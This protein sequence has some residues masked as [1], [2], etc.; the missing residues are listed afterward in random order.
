MTAAK[1]FGVARR[2]VIQA[3]LAEEV[4]QEAYV[5]IWTHA[6]SFEAGRASPMSWM[7]AIVRN[8]AIDVRRRAAQRIADQ[9]VA[10]DDVMVPQAGA[11]E[12]AERMADLRQLRECLE[13]LD[14]QPRAM[15]LLAYHLG[16]TREELAAKFARPVGT[17]KTILRR[18]L[19]ALKEC[20]DGK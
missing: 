4:L 18:G 5:R 17:V 3:T 6:K 7:I 12:D 13:G 19:A 14:E 2:I 11:R 1:L 15:V 10:L 20:L 9:A 8:Q 16:M